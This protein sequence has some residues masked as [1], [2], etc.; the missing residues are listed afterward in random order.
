MSDTTQAVEAGGFC[1][2][3][4]AFIA[5]RLADTHKRRGCAARL[6]N[7]FQQY[8]QQHATAH[9]V[10]DET[11]ESFDKDIDTIFKSQDN[12]G[13]GQ[14]GLTV[15]DDLTWTPDSDD[16]P[17]D[18]PAPEPRHP[19]TDGGPQLINPITGSPYAVNP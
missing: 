3:C 12:P 15:S 5:L 1:P 2:G 8:R 9:A 14:G 10:L 18:E 16:D 13:S 7:A 4:G 19:L 17:V 11:L 6:H